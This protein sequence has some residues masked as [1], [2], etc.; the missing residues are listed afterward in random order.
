MNKKKPDSLIPH[1]L[2]V[3][4]LASGE[5]LGQLEAENRLLHE[6]VDKLEKKVLSLRNE[7]A[8]MQ[9]WFNWLK[10]HIAAFGVFTNPGY[11][12]EVA[13]E[14]PPKSWR[15]GGE[16]GKVT[17][18]STVEKDPKDYEGSSV[19]IVGPDHTIRENENE[20]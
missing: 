2:L 1:G 10:G 3:D 18:A 7:R 16:G 13:W 5:R 8:A 4:K 19:L 6:L 20:P 9:Q 14:N 17:Q 12:A 15:E 11:I